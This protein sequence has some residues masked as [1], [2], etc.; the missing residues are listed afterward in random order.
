[1]ALQVTLHVCGI[2]RALLTGCSC[3]I[4]FVDFVCH[5]IKA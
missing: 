4:L 5:G 1:M 3:R 2:I